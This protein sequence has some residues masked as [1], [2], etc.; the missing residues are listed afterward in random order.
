M[1][2]FFRSFKKVSKYLGF[3]LMFKTANL[4]DIIY[5]SKG[6]DIN[7]TT[8]K[9]YLFIQNLIPSV[10]TQLMFNEATQSI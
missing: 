5:T 10:D 2:G 3:H 6:D 8:N 7:V 4:Q 1:F 9:L